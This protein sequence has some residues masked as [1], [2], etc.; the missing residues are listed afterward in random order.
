M[1]CK[2]DQTYHLCVDYRALNE[3]T[4]KDAYPLP[5]IQGTLDTLS[6]AKWFS[7]LDL[8]SGY[9]QVELTPRARRRT[10]SAA[11]SASM[12][13]DAFWGLRRTTDVSTSN[14]PRPGRNAMGDLLSKSRGHHHH[15]HHHPGKGCHRDTPTPGTSVRSATPSQTEIE[16]LQVLFLPPTGVFQTQHRHRSQKILKVQEW[17]Q[18]TCFRSPS[19]WPR[20]TDDLS[21]ILLL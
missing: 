12:E 10:L 17:S 18:P 4:I 14:R 7:T 5:R 1:A 20:T 2:K 13:C 3:R 11:G 16:T 9:W 21:N 15:H 19:A 6:T 8:A